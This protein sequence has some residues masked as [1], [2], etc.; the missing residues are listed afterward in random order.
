LESANVGYASLLVDMGNGYEKRSLADMTIGEIVTSNTLNKSFTIATNFGM[1]ESLFNSIVI[2]S[3]QYSFV[4]YTLDNEQIFSDYTM[5]TTNSCTSSLT[6]I[7]SYGIVSKHSTIYK[8]FYA[9]DINTGDYFYAN[10]NE[11]TNTVN[12]LT[13]S[14]SS[15]IVL[16]GT[17]SGAPFDVETYRSISIPTSLSN[18]GT[19]TITDATNHA[20]ALGYSASFNYAYSVEQSLTTETISN[21]E[22]IYDMSNK[23]YLAMYMDTNNNLTVNITDSSLSTPNLMGSG[24]LALNQ[25][26]NVISD[27]AA[28]KESVEIVIPTNYT[29]VSNKILIKGSRYVNVNV[30]DFLEAYIDLD[31]LEVGQAP[32]R[33]TRIISKK[34]YS[35]DTTLVEITC[36]ATI[37]LYNIGTGYQ[38]MKYSSLDNYVTTYKAITLKGF[39][40]R[41]ASLPDGTETRQSEI[42]NLVSLNTPLFRAITNKEAFDFRYLIDAFGLGLT[43][44]SKQSLV[45]I[46]GTRLDCLGILSMPSMKSFRKSSS[47]SFVDN[48]GVLQTSYV[49]VGG[50]PDTNPAFLYTMGDG[51]GASAVGYFAPYVVVNDNGRPLDVPPAMFVATTYMRKLNSNVSGIQPWTIAAGTT[52]GRIL[53]VAGLEMDFNPEDVKNLNDAMFNPIVVKRNKGFVIDTENTAL[54]LYTS[55]LSFLH[56]REVLIELERQLIAMLQDFQWKFNTQETRAEIK[57]RADSICEGIKSRQGVYNYMNICNDTNNPP[58]LIDSQVGVL[59]TAVEPIKGLGAIVANITV[60]KT[61][62]I[63]SSGFSSL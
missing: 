1:D 45:D 53:N 49:A 13:S 33:L 35:G 7:S 54:T 30:G 55:A 41:E 31:T 59:D 25:T 14:G 34:V 46:C 51:D 60:M 50:N 37:A 22:T 18:K 6:G 40:I 21:V 17:N 9:G 47:P 11:Y 61:G 62:A 3:L 19:L 27:I 4:L 16:V 42:L 29:Q 20:A 63:Q 8:D 12:L 32:K 24:L 15:Y 23:Y 48:Q 26:L 38:T 10:I 44:R 52:N 39:R 57:L 2:P 56:V 43:E 28:Y 5:I 36:D 58:T